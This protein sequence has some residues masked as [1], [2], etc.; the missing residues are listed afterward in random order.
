[1]TAEDAVRGADIICLCTSAQEPPVIAE[2]IAPGAH[3]TSVGFNPPGGE[4]DSALIEEG[5]LFVESYD[6]FQ[7]APV[8]CPELQG[9][10]PATATELGEVIS[11][12]AP[13]RESAE[14]ITMYKSMGHAM[15]DVVTANLV[16]QA[17]VAEG[18]GTHFV[19]E[20]RS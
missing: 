18:A 3:V 10:D 7:P 16:Y 6:A 2:W 8:G 4:L 9:R 11:G 14:E 5:R 17:A 20:N 1:A 12:N 19:M 15:E 13:G